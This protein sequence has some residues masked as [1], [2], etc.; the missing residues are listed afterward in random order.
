MGRRRGQRNR[1]NDKFDSERKRAAQSGMVGALSPYCACCGCWASKAKRRVR[2]GVVWCVTCCPAYSDPQGRMPGP[3]RLIKATPKPIDWA[4]A[5]KPTEPLTP[6]EV[7]EGFCA[8]VGQW[9]G[10]PNTRT[11]FKEFQTTVRPGDVLFHAN[12]NVW[13]E[14]IRVTSGASLQSAPIWMRDPERAFCLMNGE[15][16]LQQHFRR[17]RE[18][19]PPPYVNAYLEATA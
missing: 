15:L 8:S 6:V 13:Y 9:L 18:R 5:P 10:I 1:E 17:W 14:V 16:K 3:P 11:D 12:Q 19:N 7:S 4:K 2:N